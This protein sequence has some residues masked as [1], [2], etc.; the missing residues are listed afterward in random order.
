MFDIFFQPKTSPIKVACY[1]IEASDTRAKHNDENK[2]KAFSFIFRH[3]IYLI[4]L[5]KVVDDHLALNSKWASFPSL[6]AFNRWLINAYI[7]LD[8][9]R[10]TPEQWFAGSM[11]RASDFGSEGSGFESLVNRKSTSFWYKGLEC[12]KQSIRTYLWLTIS[13]PFLDEKWFI[14][15]KWGTVFGSPWIR[16]RSVERYS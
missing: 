13:R 16:H 3:P 5:S 6:S 8:Y 15:R 4:H 11:D 12:T 9:D 1:F 2:S 14:T 10:Q 7:L